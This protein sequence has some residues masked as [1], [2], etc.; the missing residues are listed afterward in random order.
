MSIYTAPDSL[1][2]HCAAATQAVEIGDPA[3][4]DPVAAY[5]DVA[6]L[7]EV[8]LS[9]GADSVHPGYGFVSEN[10]EFAAQCAANNIT[11]VGP[12]A[13]ALALFGDKVTA[14][15]LAVEVGVP[16][17]PGSATALTSADDAAA[18]ISAVAGLDYPVMLKAS[19]GG[20][21]RGMRMV[22]ADA[23]LSEAFEAC[24]REALAAFGNGS[25]FVEKFVTVRAC[26]RRLSAL[27]VSH[28]KPFL[29]G[30]VL[31]GAQGA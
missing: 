7:I 10:S 27:S 5:L 30:A 26:L 2:L 3:S 25:V 21:G 6:A 8:A 24:S 13:S 16:V 29:C 22:E 31:C 4:S 9:A 1:S 11:F 14:R 23:G 19:A 17:V 12:P 18:A 20:G 15:A 28:R